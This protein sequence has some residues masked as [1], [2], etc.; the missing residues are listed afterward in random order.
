MPI[1]DLLHARAGD[2][3]AIFYTVLVSWSRCLRWTGLLTLAKKVVDERRGCEILGGRV[4][5]AHGGAW[6]VGA[7]SENEEVR[8]KKRKR[9]KKKKQKK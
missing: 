6:C 1:V 8:L 2:S 9:E 5:D 3:Q 4:G 7:V